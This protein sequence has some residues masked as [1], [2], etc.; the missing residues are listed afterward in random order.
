V[1]AGIARSGGARLA[2]L[3]T[4]DELLAGAHDAIAVVEP[5][6]EPE[7]LARVAR[8]WLDPLV[9]ALDARRIAALTIVADGGGAAASWRVSPRRWLDRLRGRRSRFEA[10]RGVRR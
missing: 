7:G 4:C 6:Q 1:A 5:L 9:A 3:T 2:A 8:A 10:P